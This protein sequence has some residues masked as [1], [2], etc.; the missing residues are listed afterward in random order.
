MH[1]PSKLSPVF[2][3][4]FLVLDTTVDTL[5]NSLFSSTDSALLTLAA[6]PLVRQSPQAW[7]DANI[8]C[9]THLSGLEC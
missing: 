5:C 8:I 9:K 2:L 7:M 6:S 1:Y 3:S 4:L